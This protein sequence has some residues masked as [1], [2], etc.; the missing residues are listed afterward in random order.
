MASHQCSISWVDLQF[1][2]HLECIY[3]ITCE[4]TCNLF[5]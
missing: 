4:C 1:F 3:T 5:I 2:C